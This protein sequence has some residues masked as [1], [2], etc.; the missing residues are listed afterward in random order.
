MKFLPLQKRKKMV[1]YPLIKGGESMTK[2]SVIIP[3]YNNERYLNRCIHSLKKQKEK[4]IEFILVDDGS[5]DRSQEI[6]E[7]CCASDPR[8]RLYYFPVNQGVSIARNFGISKATGDYIGFVDSDDY[9]DANYFQVLKE[10]M[11]QTHAPMALAGY[12]VGHFRYRFQGEINYLDSKTNLQ[13]GGIAVWNHL[14]RR[15]LIGEDR[16]LE[17]CLCCE[18][19]AFSL[20]MHMKGK[21]LVATDQTFYHYSVGNPTSCNSVIFPSAKSIEARFQVADY[22]GEKIKGDSHQFI[23][24]DR[25]LRTQIYL[26]LFCTKPIKDY[27]PENL[28]ICRDLYN[29]LDVLIRQKYLDFRE[30]ITLEDPAILYAWNLLHAEDFHLQ[31]KYEKLD[32]ITSTH[33][34]QKK[35]FNYI[36]R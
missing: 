8:F 30:I 27:T 5:K 24:Q 32:V 25:I 10:K 1:K 6:I 21:R 36:K 19:T 16:F 4:E 35:A 18:D 26:L 33:L 22:L 11:D 23:Y 29:H 17:E 13:A 15:D 3:N 12:Q 34:F 2:V 7:S 9:I 28:E 31:K 20:W 14:F